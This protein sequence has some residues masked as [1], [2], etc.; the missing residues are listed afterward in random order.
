MVWWGAGVDVARGRGSKK[1]GVFCRHTRSQS[2]TC[3]CRAVHV[4]SMGAIQHTYVVA[5]AWGGMRETRERS[6][7]AESFRCVEKCGYILRTYAVSGLP[8]GYIRGGTRVVRIALCEK[9]IA[10]VVARRLGF[11]CIPGL[12]PSRFQ[13]RGGA[14]QRRVR[15]GWDGGVAGRW[16]QQQLAASVEQALANGWRCAGRCAWP[17]REVGRRGALCEP[18]CRLRGRG[19]VCRCR[20]RA[21]RPGRSAAAACVARRGGLTIRFTVKVRLFSTS[22]SK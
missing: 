22:I 13:A 8:L 14:R 2:Y 4:R 21:G 1:V 20:P 9:G 16:Q 5:H 11:D 12:G 17:G 18:I 6:R 10:L 7:R 19:F 3:G 15:G